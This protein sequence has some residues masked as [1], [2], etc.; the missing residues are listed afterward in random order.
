MNVEKVKQN[1]PTQVENSSAII[2]IFR[3]TLTYKQTDRLTHRQIVG[4]TDR[5]AGR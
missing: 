2:R 5:Q 4:K 1:T 3:H